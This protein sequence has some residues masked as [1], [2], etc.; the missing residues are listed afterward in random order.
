MKGIPNRSHSSSTASE[1]LSPA[2]NRFCTEAICVTASSALEL[3]DAHVADP[4][5]LDLPLLSQLDE[6]SDRL[7]DR[8]RRVD[9]VQLIQAAHAR[10]AGAA[11]CPRRPSAGARAGRC[12]TRGSGPAV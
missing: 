2:L 7:L 9:G 11:G 10:C 5:V 8:N 4:D 1:P 6:R 12:A 3:R